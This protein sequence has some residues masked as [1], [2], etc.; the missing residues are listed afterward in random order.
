MIPRGRPKQIVSLGTAS[1]QKKRFE[2]P[3]QVTDV[4]SEIVHSLPFRTTSKLKGHLTFFLPPIDHGN[5]RRSRLLTSQLHAYFAVHLHVS[6]LP[7]GD[8]S[9]LNLIFFF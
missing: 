6:V 2:I 3:A 7:A 8:A 5:H 4:D 1:L 9:H